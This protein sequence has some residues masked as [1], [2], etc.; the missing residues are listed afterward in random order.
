MSFIG[1]LAQNQ[2][3]ESK[4]GQV[5]TYVRANTTSIALIGHYFYRRGVEN[6]QE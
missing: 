6:V 5:V 3:F 1:A 4:D 2:V